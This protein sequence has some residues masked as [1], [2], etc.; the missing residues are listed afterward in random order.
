VFNPK[1]LPTGKN[2]TASQSLSVCCKSSNTGLDFLSIVQKNNLAS[3]LKQKDR[4][5][6]A[7]SKIHAFGDINAW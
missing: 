4:L 1:F 2:K 6:L 5:Q 7:V 3:F